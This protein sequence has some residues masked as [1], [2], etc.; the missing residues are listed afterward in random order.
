MTRLSPDKSFQPTLSS[1][2]GS[3]A[4]AAELYRS[5]SRLGERFERRRNQYPLQ[6]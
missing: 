2:L 6:L 5:T 3:S 1:S 4:A